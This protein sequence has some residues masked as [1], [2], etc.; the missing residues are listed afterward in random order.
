[1]K[2]IL[3]FLFACISAAL[4]LR[5]EVNVELAG[6]R[7]DNLNHK[8]IS[9]SN[10][11]QEIMNIHNEAL[12]WWDV[13]KIIVKENL[14][15]SSG[16]YVIE[17]C[18]KLDGKYETIEVEKY[19]SENGLIINDS[20]WYSLRSLYMEVLKDPIN[21][22]EYKTYLTYSL[23]NSLILSF[24]LFAILYVPHRISSAI[25]GYLK[26]NKSLPAWYGKYIVRIVFILPVVFFIA[27]VLRI[28]LLI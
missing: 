1:M 25:Y 10:S 28:F 16:Y 21:S 7:L 24:I 15:A 5:P 3:F 6:C 4:S 14:A 17:K 20:D 13:D 18:Q 12:F 8:A 11:S 27:L 19:I 9:I 22:N 2:V 26:S 23:V